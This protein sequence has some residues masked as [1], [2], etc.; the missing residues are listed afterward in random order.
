MAQLDDLR[1]EQAYTARVQQQLLRSIDEA[2]AL[3]AEHLRS[4][5]AIAADA[6]EELRLKP[7]AL[8]VEDMEQLAGE[9]DRFAARRDFA[10]T[11]AER[12]QR[13]LLNPF[14]ARVDFAEPGESAEKIVIGLY[15]LRDD[16]GA[17][18]VHDWRAP[19]CSL[20][21]DATPGPAAYESPSGV[22]AGE[23]TLK[24]QYRMENGRLAYYVD[25]QLSID[26]A[27]LLDVLSGAASRR[28]R[29][30]VS[31]IQ[32][33]Q[34]AAIRAQ[35]QRVVCVAGGAGSGKTSVAMHRAAY[36]MYRQR[37]VLDA[38][39]ILIISPSTA[40]S[41][42][43][44]GVLP[45]LGEE[46]IPACTLH[47]VV[48]DILGRRVERPYAQLNALLGENGDGLRRRSA[49][50]KGG[51]AFLSAMRRAADAFARLGPA[52]SDVVLDD[53]VLIP[54]DELRRMYRGELS[55]LTPAQKLMR[56]RATLD[57]RLAGME[58]RLFQQYA[59]SLSGRYGP[60]ALRQACSVAVAQRLQ[61][62]RSQLRAMLDVTGADVMA[63]LMEAAPPELAEAYAD[64]RAAEITWWEDA[65]AEAYFSVALGFAA[66][67][68][69]IL[70]LLVD[71]AQDHTDAA[72]G[73]L[74]V[75]FPRAKVTILGD[76]RQRT[77]PGLPPCDPRAW[78]ACFGAPDAPLYPL[79]RCYRST[80]QI[81]ALL[82][83]ILDGGEAPPEAAGAENAPWREEPIEPCGRDGAPPRVA[84]WSE[85]AL[86]DALAE[87]RAAGHRSI[88]VITRTQAQADR[89]SEALAGVYRL[90]GGEADDAYEA[91]D[92]V[93]ACY[94][95]TKGLEFD[96]VIVCWPKVTWS[97]DE[98]RRLYT[99]CS[100][101]LHA[102][103]VLGAEDLLGEGQ[104]PAEG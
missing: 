98:R 32:A 11:T 84:A 45:E 73:M 46:N 15:A 57:T 86:R 23:L 26:D 75:C 72:L 44:S 76:P 50:W 9:V 100:R 7:T 103:T 89:L 6:W 4:I 16:A 56:M 91:G 81:A 24:R 87:Y 77:T 60:G 43:V 92:N 21:Y 19:V 53:Q 69:D 59:Q 39:R 38:K 18:L 34:N 55:L 88:A 28:M 49:A 85:N 58:S 29:Q 74:A 25:T 51:A 82:S 41:Q 20:Y 95:L 102:L 33:E 94:H 96:A 99:A 47:A 66:P 30:I 2:Q 67:R 36:L 31:T 52:F 1:A 35:G 68:K 61:P 13:M 64:N 93:V 70:H 27:L 79:N 80:R 65:V 104:S 10:N 97:G 78:G 83:K 90:D 5:Q 12:A 42:Y 62:V 3:S 54:G 8:S 101:A 48:E 17:L 14:F 40:F 71:E 63:Q 37:D 22:I